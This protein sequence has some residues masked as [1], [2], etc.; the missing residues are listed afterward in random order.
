MSET[1]EWLEADGLGGFASSTTSGIR[2]R[3]YHALLLTATNPPA[4][5]TVLVNGFDAWLEHGGTKFWLS[6]Q[7]YAPDVAGKNEWLRSFQFQPWPQWSY[8][9]ALDLW[10]D[11]EIFVPRGQSMVVISWRLSG[12]VE[13]DYK[14]TVKP[15]LSG[16]DYHSSHHQNDAFRFEP[17]VEANSLKWKPYDGIPT[18]VCRSRA[19]Y[20]HDP[21][22]YRNFLYTQERE[23]GLD[24]LEDLA[25]PGELV[26]QLDSQTREAIL[27]FD[28]E[29]FTEPDKNSL[30]DQ[31][32]ELRLSE[33]ERRSK[34]NDLIQ[35]SGETYFVRRGTGKSIIAGYPWFGDW[36]RDTFISIRGLGIASGELEVARDI[37]LE[38]ANH[39]S[40]GMLPNRFPDQGAVPEYN[41]V[42]ASLW[43]IIAAGDVLDAASTRPGLVDETAEQKLKAAIDAILSGYQKGT[44]FRIH[45]DEDGLLAAGVPGLQLTWMDAKVDGQ[46]ITPRVGK[47][48]EVQALWIN[49]LAIGKK[50]SVQWEKVF[51]KGRQTF[52]NRFWNEAGQQLF[53]VLD[54]DHQPG[55]NDPATRPNQIFAVGGLPL[56]LLSGRRARQVVDR[57]E[58]KLWTPSGLRSLAQD[59]PGF[60][61]HYL[62]GPKERD[63]AYH[64]GTVWPWLAGAFIEAW[65]R[66]RGNT[67]EAK[68]E[69]RERYFESI[70][71]LMTA[72][73]LNHVPEITDAIEP[74]TPRGCPFQAWSLGELLRLDRMVLTP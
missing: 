21:Q 6:A 69:A 52:E 34:K 73:G 57:V 55:V 17:I 66:V 59:E 2:T 19:S 58:A 16:R 18:I 56:V 67:A 60:V 8:Q 32:A 39:V 40:E 20:H 47:P 74:Y 9:L 15:F 44:R 62:G 33:R 11:H 50:F 28:T 24:F 68:Q 10:L 3:R 12:R 46:V 48:V 23:R 29:G 35:R 14:L 45:Q 1:H 22:W 36:G 51:E 37:L 53:D 43:F 31:V 54:V 42:D 63:S 30:E 27:T 64:Q 70:R 4:G 7:R 13:E 41:S 49:A 38:W 71:S 26:W 65:V 72:A 25:A 5:R 61:P